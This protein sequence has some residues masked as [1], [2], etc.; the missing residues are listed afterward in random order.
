MA[1]GGLVAELDRFQRL[2]I[3]PSTTNSLPIVKAASSEARNTIAWAIS[4]EFPRRP[5]GIEA[6]IASRSASA[7]PSLSISGV[8]VGPGLTAARA[9]LTRKRARQRYQHGLGGRIYARARH[10]DARLDR[11]GEHDRGRIGE[12]RQQSLYE[13]ERTLEIDRNRA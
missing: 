7:N 10:A 6:T 1:A 12:D 5:A 13:E 4:L 2:L 8:R 9:E 3:P 11:G